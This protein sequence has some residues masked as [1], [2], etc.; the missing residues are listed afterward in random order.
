MNKE[1]EALGMMQNQGVRI[2]IICRLKGRKGVMEAEERLQ[3][4]QLDAWR[5]ISRIELCIIKSCQERRVIFILHSAH[6]MITS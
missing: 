4:E 1:T 6:L 5:K 2:I 3:V